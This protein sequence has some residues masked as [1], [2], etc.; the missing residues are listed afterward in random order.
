[1]GSVETKLQQPLKLAPFVFEE[2]PENVLEEIAERLDDA[3]L[4]HFS[5]TCKRIR[6][7]CTRVSERRPLFHVVATDPRMGAWI[8]EQCAHDE[9]FQPVRVMVFGKY[10]GKSALVRRL[11]SNTWTE[12][13]GTT[14]GTS[15]KK[16]SVK[17]LGSDIAL[18]LWEV[19]GGERFLGALAQLYYRKASV[20]MV[21]CCVCSAHGRAEESIVAAKERICNVRSHDPS[22]PLLLVGTMSDQEADLLADVQALAHEQHVPF[23][24][25]SAKTGEGVQQ[26]FHVATILALKN[27]FKEFINN[28]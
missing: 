20:V 12:T 19:S 5:L 17:V 23:L 21:L 22:M 28:S 3:S 8:A 1:M 10:A 11:V 26:A 15:F 6:A 24:V 13:T 27:R 2:A 14:V 7:I 25:T 18:E 4:A 9:K 16:H